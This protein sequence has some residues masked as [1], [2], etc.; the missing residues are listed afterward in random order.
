MG[1]LLIFLASLFVSCVPAYV[2]Y[3]GFLAFAVGFIWGI[4]SFGC[5]RMLVFKV[6]LICWLVDTLVTTMFFIPMTIIAMGSTSVVHLPLLAVACYVAKRKSQERHLAVFFYVLAFCLALILP[7][8][9]VVLFEKPYPPHPEE[10]RVSSDDI[11]DKKPQFIDESSMWCQET[12][13]GRFKY[14]INK[15]AAV[16]GLDIAEIEDEEK[17]TTEKLFSTYEQA[18]AYAKQEEIP[19]IPSV[20]MVDHKAKVFDDA[21]YAAIEEYVQNVASVLGGGKRVFLRNVLNELIKVD[22]GSL[23]Y[24]Q[25]QA[26]IATGLSLGGEKLPPLSEKTSA[27][28]Q[29]LEND[30]L[31]SPIRSKPIGFYAEDEELK[32]IFLQDRFYQ[33]CLSPE[34]AIAI[35]RSLNRNPNLRTQYQALLLL[36]SHLTNP[37]SRFSVNDVAEYADFFDDPAFLIE[38]MLQSNKWEV[39]KERGAGREPPVPC[40]QFLPH[41]TSKENQLF[42]KVYNYSSELPEHNVMNQL[43]KAIR[44]DEIDL[45]PTENSGW[46]DYQIYALETL[47]APEKGQEG[48]KLLLT[49]A[50]KEKLIEAFKTILTKKR[51]LHVKQVEL[52]VTLGISLG[53]SYF[54]ISPDLNLEP[55]ATYYLRTARSYRFIVNVLEL[56]LSE[57]SLQE[58]S[59]KSGEPLQIAAEKMSKLYYGLYLKVC[60]DIGMKP[61]FLADEMS[62]TQIQEAKEEAAQ[63][64]ADYAKDLCYEKDVRYIVPVLANLNRTKVRYWMTIGVKVLKVKAEYIK[65][66]LIQILDLESDR[67]I[68]EIP[69]NKETGLISGT[70]L[71]YKFTPEEYY[72]PVEVFAEATG[73]AKPL[74]RDE[75]RRL[76]H[77]CRNEKEVIHAIAFRD[78]FS[79]FRITVLTIIVGIGIITILLLFRICQRK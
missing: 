9:M 31:S 29:E 48:E 61:A 63:W 13:D 4:C 23:G 6:F 28:Q 71:Q 68:Q 7:H 47:L 55:M 8:Y 65:R 44:A 70:H 62:S 38:Q 26:Y 12:L 41:S 79:A 25:A 60:E 59:L 16:L 3:I 46:Y 53:P 54:R 32:H 56:F 73:P 20:Q 78:K 5:H 72:L 77:K 34:A 37:A 66:P 24:T 51:E 39:L 22:D 2:A 45:T 49:K 15:S 18:L 19:V 64:L 58:I 40:I 14:R 17:E 67:I 42:A 43:I 36:Y 69:T 33:T 10:I 57:A 35:A 27:L 75:F 76:C 11:E 1:G 30:F 74:T 21:L 52:V 50:Y